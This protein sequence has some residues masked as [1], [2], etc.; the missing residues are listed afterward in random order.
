M[1]VYNPSDISELLNVKESTLR[2]YSIM[3]EKAGYEFQKN[4][5]KQRQYSDND[6]IT[7]RKLITHKNNG[8][9]LE[10]SVEG[11]VLWHKGGETDNAVAHVTDN[12]EQRNKSDITELK[13][14]I[15]KQNEMIGEMSKRLDQQQEYLDKR[16]NERDQLLMQTLNESMETRKMIAAAEEKEKQSIWSKLFK[17]R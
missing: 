1:K 8:M 15:E 16:L 13:Q 5:R 2:K 11:V 4:S 14:L 7:L 3:L 9:T 12:A 10:E 17:K 6:I